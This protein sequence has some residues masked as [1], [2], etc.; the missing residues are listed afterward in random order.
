MT[1]RRAVVLCILIALL[2]APAAAASVERTVASLP[3]GGF[4]VTLT[5]TD[6]PVGGIVETIPDGCTWAGTD[7]PENR[8]RVSGQHVAF[9]VVGEETVRYRMQGPAEA[10][11][12]IAGTWEDLQ[13]GESGTVGSDGPR[14]PGEAAQTTAPGAPGFE[15]A[16]AL[17]ALVVLCVRR[18]GR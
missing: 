1:P 17:A 12:E 9:A 2:A 15:W 7:H 16:A 14:N 4:E 5:V 10:G 11:E 18:C 6:I 3:E 13:A 8:T